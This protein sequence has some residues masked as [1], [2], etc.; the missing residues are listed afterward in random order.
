MNGHCMSPMNIKIVLMSED[1][2]VNE[3]PMQ[4][5]SYKKY[6][7]CSICRKMINLILHN[8]MMYWFSNFVET[9]IRIRNKKF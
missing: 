7:H 6:M 8:L 1:K 3:F 9:P 5:K 2:N 4:Q